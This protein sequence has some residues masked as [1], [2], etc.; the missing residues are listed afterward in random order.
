MV[1]IEEKYCGVCYKTTIHGNGKCSEC[2][3]RKHKDQYASI[4]TWNAMDL[5]DKLNDL[6]ERVEDLERGEPRC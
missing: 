1:Y 6:R 3:E 4:R 5:F 2:A